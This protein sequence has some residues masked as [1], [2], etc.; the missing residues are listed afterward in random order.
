M[1]CDSCLIEETTKRVKKGSL[2]LAPTASCANGQNCGPEQLTLEG[3]LGWKK[4]GH[5][6]SFQ[7]IFLRPCI[8]KDGGAKEKEALSMSVIYNNL[9]SLHVNVK[10]IHDNSYFH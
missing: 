6:I 3:F 7:I 10:L 9:S 8:T 2:P 4:S 5:F 1:S